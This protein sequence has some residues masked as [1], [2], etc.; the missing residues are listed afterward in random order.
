MSPTWPSGVSA[1]SY[2]RCAIDIVRFGLNDSLRLASCWRVEVVNGGAGERFC[3]RTPTLRTTGCASRSAV[4]CRSAVASSGT[5]S[6]SPSIRTSS[7]GNVSPA[8]VARMASIVQY[9]RAVK[10]L[11]LAFALDDEPDGDRLDPAGGQAATDLARQ[12]RAERVADQPIDDPT[13]LLGV[14]EVVVDV[15]RV[16]ERRADRRAP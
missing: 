7:A 15:A 8:A 3:V 12:Q 4:T 9:S 13:R 16:G 14:D 11:D 5:A 6:A 2:S 1:P 10:A